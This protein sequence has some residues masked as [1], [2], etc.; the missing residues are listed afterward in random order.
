MN[1]Q[2]TGNKFVGDISMSDEIVDPKSM[3]VNE[4]NFMK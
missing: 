3:T 4:F 1:N 2:S